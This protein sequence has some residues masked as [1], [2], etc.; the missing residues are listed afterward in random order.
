M[1]S[2]DLF[3]AS[4]KKPSKPES[5]TSPKDEKRV[6]LTVIGS[7]QVSSAIEQSLE[8]IFIELVLV[9]SGE[10]AVE[11]LNKNAVSL[12]ISEINLP[13]MNGLNLSRKIKE[14]EALRDVPVLLISDSDEGPDKVMGM[15]TGADD[16]VTLPIN[17]S[18]LRSRVMALISR[19][20]AGQTGTKSPA[21]EK[22]IFED[23]ILSSGQGAGV[24]TIPED[25]IGLGEPVEISSDVSDSAMGIVEEEFDSPHDAAAQPVEEDV[26][27]PSESEITSVEEMLNPKSPSEPPSPNPLRPEAI[28]SGTEV[29]DAAKIIPQ[30]EIL[31]GKSSDNSVQ[32]KEPDQVVDS[33]P[34]LDQH[35]DHAGMLDDIFGGGSSTESLPSV[36]E[37]ESKQEQIEHNILPTSTPIVNSESVAPLEQ[38]PPVPPIEVVATPVL[39]SPAQTPMPDSAAEHHTQPVQIEGSAQQPP[40][41]PTAAPVS[42]QETTMAPADI[43]QTTVPV[44]TPVEPATVAE[45][46]L[47]SQEPIASDG[48]EQFNEY[49]IDTAVDHKEIHQSTI[50]HLIE[51]ESAIIQGGDY[52]FTDIINDANKIV[53]SVR[54]SNYLQIRAISKRDGGDFPVHSINVTI[55]SVKLATGLKYETKNLV[56]LAVASLLHDIGM[57][58]IPEDIRKAQR[59]LSPEEISTLKLHPQHGS[60]YLTKAVQTHLELATFPFLPIVAFQ[61]HERMNGTGYPN[62]IPGDEIHEYAKIISIIDMYEAVSHP[63]NYRDEYL[64]YEALQKVVALKDTHFDVKLLRALVRE[65]SIFPIDSVVK[66]NDGQ[67]GKVIGLEPSHPMRPKLLLLYDSEG[68]KY[69]E[70]N[71]LELSKSPFL[72]VAV[73]VSEED[74]EKLGN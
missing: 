21:V 63:S 28:Q 36:D 66:L 72:Y 62:S 10:A 2:I 26:S 22:E 49:E 11:Y 3:R 71:E 14:D 38:P 37:T 41:N 16:Y 8:S 15:E 25:E 12:V 68:N 67:I 48:V 31:T 4:K 32:E 56:E 57:L 46:T 61:E 70:E 39:P 73:P 35:D 1:R 24:D 64:A 13:L 40:V 6:I 33:K 54:N 34:D 59:K 20:D 60:E 58:L 9:G 23:G 69:K 44:A 5:N 65:I 45:E 51:L 19:N 27:S 43:V 7:S 52:N 42:S 17:P 18:E 50:S 74:M 55:Y 30:D 53:A 29:E 47:Q